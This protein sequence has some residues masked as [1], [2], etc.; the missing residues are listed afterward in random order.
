MY[1]KR[2]EALR[3]KK[4]LE[5]TRPDIVIRAAGG[6]GQVLMKAWSGLKVD[7]VDVEL[8]QPESAKPLTEYFKRS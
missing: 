5:H 4:A 8:A 3:A 1:E 2:A 7:C 6:D